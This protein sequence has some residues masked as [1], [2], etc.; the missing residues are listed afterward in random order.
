MLSFVLKLTSTIV[1]TMQILAHTGEKIAYQGNKIHPTY[2]A[3]TFFQRVWI[4]RTRLIIIHP[5]IWR[6]KQNYWALCCVWDWSRFQLIKINKQVKQ[7]TWYTC[8]LHLERWPAASVAGQPRWKPGNRKITI[9]WTETMFRSYYIR[10]IYNLFRPRK[11]L[12]ATIAS[13]ND[14]SFIATAKKDIAL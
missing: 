11:S 3:S 6:N 8:M 10:G 7:T 4:L 13:I 2:A 5:S 12:R 1:I 9:K 14:G